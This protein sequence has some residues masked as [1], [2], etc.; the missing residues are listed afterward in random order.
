MAHKAHHFKSP[1]T[2]VEFPKKFVR[3]H[4]SYGRHVIRRAKHVR[5]FEQE[6]EGGEK[7]G[8]A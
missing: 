7:K 6:R 8:R 1:Q 4:C 3:T 2:A 5:V